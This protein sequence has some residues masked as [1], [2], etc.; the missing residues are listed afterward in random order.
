MREQTWVDADGTAVG[1][2][3]YAMFVCLEAAFGWAFTA[4]TPVV[5]GAVIDDQNL[6]KVQDHL[7]LNV[8]ARHVT[9]GTSRRTETVLTPATATAEGTKEICVYCAGGCGEI[10]ERYTETIPATGEPDTPD[11]PADPDSPADDGLCK[12]CGKDHSVNFWQKI[13]GFFHSVIY[14]FAHLFGKR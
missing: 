13:V 11:D 2:R 1:G 14:F 9:D 7:E 10:V 3:D 12:W 4:E 6:L 5:S 8:T